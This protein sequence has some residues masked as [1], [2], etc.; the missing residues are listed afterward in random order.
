MASI[1][2]HWANWET[3]DQKVAWRESQNLDGW[4]TLN[5]SSGYGISPHGTNVGLCCVLKSI[6]MR[7]LYPGDNSWTHCLSLI[8]WLSSFLKYVFAL[9]IVCQWRFLLCCANSHGFNLLTLGSERHLRSCIQKVQTRLYISVVSY[10]C[11]K[12]NMFL[13]LGQ[14]DVS[15]G[16][17]T[18][19]LHSATTSW[20]LKTS[21][22]VSEH[23]ADTLN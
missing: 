18:K 13:N 16:I 21:F 12:G 14:P 8:L 23:F 10:T 5:K 19:Q 3:W 7:P 17:Y 1:L 9:G 11:I 15:G 6:L 22:N 2:R 4:T 20:R